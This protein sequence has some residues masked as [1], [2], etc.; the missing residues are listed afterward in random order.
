MKDD[1]RT[2]QAAGFLA[3]LLLTGGFAAAQDWLPA[4]GFESPADLERLAGRAESFASSRQAGDMPFLPETLHYRMR[5]F[6]MTGGVT[7]TLETVSI[8]GRPLYRIRQAGAVAG[9]RQ[10]EECLLET[11]TLVPARYR[12]DRGLSGHESRVDQK[13]WDWLGLRLFAEGA[14]QLDGR[15]S[16]TLYR[17][18]ERLEADRPDAILDPLAA[19]LLY[20]HAARTA[21][22]PL[23]EREWTVLE[24]NDGVYQAVFQPKSA[25]VAGNH[26]V[27][28][29]CRLATVEIAIQRKPPAATEN[30]GRVRL[31]L[32]LDKQAIPVKYDGVWRG[33]PFELILTH[34]TVQAAP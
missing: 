24:G 27:L 4:A 18:V 29:D 22:G 31:D 17:R 5:A 16:R 2:L 8:A 15:P 9:R 25:P 19:V 26:P 28:G 20:R 12:R 1:F 10:A 23:P 6:G 21:A 14:L 30:A 13:D 7:Q 34:A 33:I 32:A 11:G 3:V